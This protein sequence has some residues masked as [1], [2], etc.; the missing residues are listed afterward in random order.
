MTISALVAI[1]FATLTGSFHCAG[2]CGAFVTI[3]SG[4]SADPLKKS[5]SQQMAYHLGRL[6]TYLALGAFAGALGS[7]L[8]ITAKL[9]GLQPVAM[10]LAGRR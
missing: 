10:I 5:L 4:S 1:L 6:I 3:A 8:N 9:A 7:L 2:M